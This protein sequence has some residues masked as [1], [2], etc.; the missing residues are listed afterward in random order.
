MRLWLRLTH[1]FG[2]PENHHPDNLMQA[3]LGRV[4]RATCQDVVNASLPEPIARLFQEL[5]Q[6]EHFVQSLERS[7]S[8][9][10][11]GGPQG[12]RRIPRAA[13]GVGKGLAQFPSLS[14]KPAKGRVRRSEI[15]IPISGEPQPPPTAQV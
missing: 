13:T 15:S 1:L 7:R 8:L 14:P 10:P 3:A 12:Q 6:R 4:L 5:T 11:T 2:L 9:T